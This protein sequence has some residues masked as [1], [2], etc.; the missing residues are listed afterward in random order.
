MLVQPL[1]LPDALLIEPNIFKD[2]RGYFFE[3]F[4]HQAFRDCT[5]LDVSF[6]QD[7][8]SF[9]SQNVFRGLHYQVP[10][11][12]QG[13]LVRVVNGE[14]F[15]VVVDIRPGSKSFAQ[16]TGVKLSGTN[17][18]QLW[19]PPGFAHGFL[20]LSE[21]ATFLYKVTNYFS[22]SH[23]AAI[24]WDDPT[25]GIQ[26]PKMNDIIISDKDA[27]APLIGSSKIYKPAPTTQL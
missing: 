2:D 17:H 24:R 19:V 18:R 22:K 13:K 25:I 4:N 12:E 20:V 21:H 11:M 6:V 15:D 8:Q 14:V 10:P 26:L 23:E 16:W 9:S 3:S 5:G 7:N 27:S 1:D